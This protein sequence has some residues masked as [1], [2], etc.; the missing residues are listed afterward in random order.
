[1]VFDRFNYESNNEIRSAINPIDVVVE[2]EILAA[3]PPRR[4][5]TAAVGFLTIDR[6]N[7]RWFITVHNSNI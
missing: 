1:M 3:K 7:T 6:Y 4:R 5:C 2:C